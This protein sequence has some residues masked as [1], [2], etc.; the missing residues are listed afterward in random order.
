MGASEQALKVEQT[1]DATR[2]VARNTAYLAIGQVLTIPLG[3]LMS[4]MM[5]RFFGAA[6]FGYLYAAGTMCS[7]G[8]LVVEWGQQGALPALIAKE[9]TLAGKLLGTGFAWRV[10]AAV[11]VYSVLAVYSVVRNKG[12]EFQ[13]VLALSFAASLVTSLA[14]GFKDA[15]RGFERME[16]PAIAHVGQQL[17][18]ATLV[19]PLMFLGVGLKGVLFTQTLVAAVTVWQLS[20]AL[21]GFG[22]PGLSL[23]RSRIVPLLAIG[24]PFVFFDIAMALRPNIDVFFLERYSPEKTMGWL[25]VSQRLLAQLLLPATALIGGLYPTL[26]RLWS[27]SLEGFTSTTRNALKGISVIVVPIAL[28]CAL[29][30]ELGIMLFSRK[31]FGPAEDNLRILAIFLFLVYFTM[32]LGTAVLAAGKRRAW[33]LVQAVCLFV[34]LGIDP[35]LVPWFQEHRGNGGLGVCVASVL[36]ELIV[37][38]GSILLAPRGSIDLSVFRTLGLSLL[39]GAAMAGVAI[40]MFGHVS[41]FI[42]AP[43]AITVYLVS[44]LLT[45]AIDPGQRNAVLRVA[46]RKLARFF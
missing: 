7:L 26:C 46:R 23:E 2:L 18:A 3:I 8:I 42:G 40:A 38:S 15:I 31:E 11:L 33:S 28:S 16:I 12:T 27:E 41:P 10:S 6:E 20:R 36:S 32:P 24:T 43:I 35:L 29:Y 45:G 9:R 22:V 19:I 1:V 34:S 25:A 14:G 30:P 5:G 37:L 4:V 17:L 21:R 44:A 39:S 13:W